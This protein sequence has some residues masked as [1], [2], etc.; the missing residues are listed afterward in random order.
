MTYE[1]AYIKVCD[2]YKKSEPIKSLI[3]KFLYTLNPE[4]EYP[5]LNF[6]MWLV[7]AC[8]ES[9]DDYSNPILVLCMAEYLKSQS[10]WT[11]GTSD[12]PLNE[13]SSAVLTA[14]DAINWFSLDDNVPPTNIIS[15]ASRYLYN[16]ESINE[17]ISGA[18]LPLDISTVSRLPDCGV[19]YFPRHEVMRHLA[20]IERDYLE[21]H[22]INPDMP[23]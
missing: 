7:W 12:V 16:N 23:F 15:S 13:T 11:A 10:T 21:K 22:Y 8:R 2:G 1:E 5:S 19:E 18:Y 3:E 6:D 17:I 20:I 4:E 9:H 14:I